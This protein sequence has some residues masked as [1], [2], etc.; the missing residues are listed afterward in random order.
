MQ[1]YKQLWF[2]LIVVSIIVS[3]EEPIKE[4]H[5]SDCKSYKVII[6]NQTDHDIPYEFDED[7]KVRFGFK[8]FRKPQAKMLAAG[9]DTN[10]SMI[11]KVLNL[12]GQRETIRSSLVLGLKEEKDK[13]HYIFLRISEKY[14][15]FKVVKGVMSP[16]QGDGTQF[17]TIDSASYSLAEFTSLM[18]IINLDERI[19][20]QVT[21]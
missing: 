15:S 18:L 11:K 5:S 17:D 6:A 4:N 21:F 20:I 19:Q 9:S 7:V 1:V 2:L 8:T 14:N 10:F 16:W 12:K 3:M 13:R